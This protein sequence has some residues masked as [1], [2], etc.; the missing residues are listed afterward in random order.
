M[1]VLSL[2]LIALALGLAAGGASAQGAP[3][4]GESSA[5]ELEAPRADQGY[6][7]TLGLHG[8]GG[9]VF[10]DDD[11]LPIMKGSSFA[12]RTGQSVNTWMDLGLAFEYG[13]LQGPDE[14]EGYWFT[15][16][17][18]WTVNLYRPLFLRLGAGLAVADVSAPVN[19]DNSAGAFGTNG[20]L[21]L[22]YAFFPFHDDGES[23]GWALSPVLRLVS[24]QPFAESAAYIAGL[25]IELTYWSGF[26]DRQLD[27]DLN[28]VYAK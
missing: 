14:R 27:L 2:L 4:E 12:L 22:G 19:S 5:V 13:S 1:R 17:L 23:G 3:S 9:I 21:T 16:G 28:E 26:P 20:A 6:F 8:T 7:L 15:F 18:D 24:I 10:D 11:R 25:G